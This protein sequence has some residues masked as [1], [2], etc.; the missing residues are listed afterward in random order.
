MWLSR[1][2]YIQAFSKPLLPKVTLSPAFPPRVLVYLLLASTL[3]SC[4]RQNW[5]F[6]FLFTVF[7]EHT[8]LSCFSAMRSSDLGET[9]GSTLYQSLR[10]HTNRSN[11]KHDYLKTRSTLVPHETGTFN[12]NTNCHLQDY[13]HTRNRIEQG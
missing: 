13:C 11:R 10:K 4:S 2:S 1:Y 12:G 7:N 9:K 3:I 5:L 8:L 6:H